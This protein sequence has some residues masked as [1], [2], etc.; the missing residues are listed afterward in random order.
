VHASNGYNG[1]GPKEKSP[2]AANFFTV[3]INRVTGVG[4]GPLTLAWR[5]H[6]DSVGNVLKPSKP[7]VVVARRIALQKGRPVRVA[8]VA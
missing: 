5:L 4:H 1:P 3:G 7:H 8:W 2:S 6:Y